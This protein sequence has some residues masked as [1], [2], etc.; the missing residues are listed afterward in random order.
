MTNR[1]SAKA[2]EQLTRRVSG[3]SERLVVLRR[4]GRAS[5]RGEAAPNAGC[6][7]A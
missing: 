3:T 2:S 5:L 1:E 6:V 7:R 4:F